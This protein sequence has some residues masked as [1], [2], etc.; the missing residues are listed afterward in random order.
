MFE[1]FSQPL[2]H[3]HKFFFR[4]VK[5]TLIG[6]LLILAALFIGMLGYHYFE[7]M[8]WIDSFANASMILSGMG[9]FGEL[10]YNS[11]KIFAGCYALFSGLMFIMVIGL[12]FAP[13]I[14]RFF[15]SMNMDEGNK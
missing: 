6:W 8:N 1:K 10:K 14:H 2:A 15:H 4:M 12:I 5:S 13:V 7:E 11:G 9:P 3:R